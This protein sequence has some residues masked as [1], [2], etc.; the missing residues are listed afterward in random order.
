MGWLG[1]LGL[2]GLIGLTK[3]RRDTEVYHGTP[4]PA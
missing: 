4:R 2:I 3:K 1:L